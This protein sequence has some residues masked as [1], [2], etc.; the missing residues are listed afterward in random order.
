M[1]RELRFLQELA[2]EARLN[3]DLFDA[4]GED[5]FIF[6]TQACR[7]HA[8]HHAKRSPLHGEGLL[9]VHPFYR[10]VEAIHLDLPDAAEKRGMMNMRAAAES[11]SGAMPVAL[12][13]DFPSYALASSG[14]AEDGLVDY[15]VFTRNWDPSP[16]RPHEAENLH[17]LSRAFLC[18]CYGGGRCLSYY[19]T[20]LY[21][22]NANSAI[23]IKDAILYSPRGPLKKLDTEF[24]RQYIERVGITTDAFVALASGYVEPRI[25]APGPL[26]AASLSP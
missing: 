9:M 17:W 14:L 4:L 12:I 11:A 19:F 1:P 3:P 24:E 7:K 6:F 16:M 2:R 20:E 15:V 22:P 18:G 13:D 21:R 23:H 10:M 8:Q 5:D 26:P 25:S